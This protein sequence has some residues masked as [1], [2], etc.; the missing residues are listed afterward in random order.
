MNK[1]IILAGLCLTL[2][3]GC[4]TTG[5]GPSAVVVLEN[6]ATIFCEE[7]GGKIEKRED[8]QR[9]EAGFCVMPDGRECDAVNFFHN[10]CELT[11]PVL[12]GVSGSEE[13]HLATE[14]GCDSEQQIC[15]EWCYY[16]DFQECV[17]E[18][19]KYK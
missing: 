9:N 4:T 17:E 12:M 7:Q 14:Q 16:P 1:K 13:Y 2:L 8:H 10:K 15:G 6:P 3:S 11:M 5:V 18:R 19:V